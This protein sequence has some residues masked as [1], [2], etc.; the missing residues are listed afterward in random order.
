MRK[1][2]RRTV[3]FGMEDAGRWALTRRPGTAQPGAPVC[4][5]AEKS[6]QAFAVYLACLRG[7]YA[8]FP[9]NAG[10]TDAEIDYLR[11]VMAGQT[12][13]KTV[14]TSAKTE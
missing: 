8:F 9:I 14:L 6:V 5:I 7:G 1:R 2:R 3:T 4:L 10:Y 12:R 13:G 11:A